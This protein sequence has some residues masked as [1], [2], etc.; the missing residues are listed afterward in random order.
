MNGIQYVTD[1]NG[2]KKAVILDIGTYEQLLEDILD[3]AAI[4]ERKQGRVQS[5]IANLSTCEGTASGYL[6]KER[7]TDGM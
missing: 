2:E 7:L 1:E 5:G 3:L 4:A 6:F